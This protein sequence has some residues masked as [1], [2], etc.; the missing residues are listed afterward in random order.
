MNQE[1]IDKI[2]KLLALATS[3]NEHEAKSAAEKA[4]A[5]LIKY[6]LKMQDI[7]SADK[8]YIEQDVS[9]SGKMS[10]E[11]KFVLGI[12]RDHFF[13]EPVKSRN[14]QN[15]TTRIYF[16]GEETNVKVATYVY[17]FLTNKFYD[18][19]IDYK[20]KTDAD[21]LHKQSY[22]LGLQTGLNEV[23]SQKRSSIENEMSLVV[24]KDPKLEEL[25]KDFKTTSQRINHR[26][27]E[28]S[29]AGKVAGKNIRISRG[30]ESHSRNQ[31]K[32]LK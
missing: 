19:W 2:S 18:L 23:L 7:V 24:I 25:V 8:N 11:D 6:N 28:A 32:Y 31:G 9:L 26:D 14:Y 13:V 30:I 20:E 22:Y 4:N 10:V 3:P 1:V 17:G 15:G 29:E 16:I 21:S 12:I 5:L 27:I